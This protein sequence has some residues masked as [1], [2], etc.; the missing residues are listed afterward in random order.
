MTEKKR[1]A[2]PIKSSASNTLP[3]KSSARA[4]T[5]D[6]LP[7]DLGVEVE[8]NV[9]GIEMGVL[10]NGMP[11]LT[12]R[13]LAA[14]SGAARATIFE[15]TR[16]WAEGFDKPTS[17]GNRLAFFQNYLFENGYRQPQLFVEVMKDG[18]PY[19]AYPDIVCMAVIEFYAF[20]AQRTNDAAIENYRR[21]AR[22]G[23]QKFIYD[24]L[25]YVPPDKWRYYHDRVSLT[26]AS[27][28]DGYFIIFH[29]ISGMIIDLI[30]A[31]LTVNDKT[32]PDISV[33][34]VWSDH[35]R[36]KNLEALFGDR[37]QYEHNYPNYYAQ[38]ASNPQ[39][40]W[41]YPNGA[42]P[43]FRRWFMHEYLTTR[44]PR[45]ILERAKQLRGGKVEAE[46]IASM[47]A[48]NKKLLG[49]KKG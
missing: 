29:E 8:K 35:W 25:G 38:S 34:R 9:G 36:A 28:P 24:A 1:K 31:G 46:A 4:A 2:A 42:L 47:Y 13:G 7:L 10:E 49:P 43:E 16:E 44:F 48:K 18:T 15:I 6:Q 12:Q 32:I 37:V 41:A 33:G 30:N 40:P 11:Y 20:E 26:A 17:P 3:A 5:S 39:T 22:Y 23:L 14:M 21:L 27:A 19:Y 45:Y